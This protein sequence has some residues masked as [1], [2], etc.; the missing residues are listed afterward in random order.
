[1][2]KILFLILTLALLVN[3]SGA[4][5]GYIV[6]D[7]SN[8]DPVF[9]SLIDD[10]GFSYE[11]IDDSAIASTDFSD[12][13]ILLVGDE[14]IDNIPVDDYKTL[15]V[16]P[17]YYESWSSSTGSTSRND[18]YVTDVDIPVTEGIPGY[19]SPYVTCSGSICPRIHYLSGQK[20]SAHPVIITD[21]SSEYI[22]ATKEDP[23][24]VFFGA[25]ETD[26]WSSYTDN[27]FKNSIDWLMNIDIN[28][29]PV[30]DDYSPSDS[31]IEILIGNSQD[32]S[33][34]ASDEDSEITINWLVNGSNSGTG[35]SYNFPGEELGNF[36]ITAVVSDGE[37][38]L[39]QE[40][41]LHVLDY[42]DFTCSQLAGYKCGSDEICNGDIFQASD[43]E[44]CSIQ[45]SEKP[46]E[47]EKIKD[48]HNISSQ[49]ELEIREPTKSSFDLGEI[50]DSEIYLKNKAGKTLDFEIKVYFYDIIDDE[51]IE[52]YRE[53]AILQKD[54]GK[55]FYPEFEIPEDINEQSRYALFVKAIGDDDEDYYSED[56][57]LF[58]I[59]RKVYD[60]SIV[61]VEVLETSIK[62]DDYVE[63]IIKTENL[64]IRD[65]DVVVR[66]T[67][68][69][70]GIN[71]E[72]EE[73]KLEKYGED[74]KETSFLT[75][76]I[77][78]DAEKGK[79][80]LDI[81]AVF[82]N[83]NVI[84]K[85]EINLDACSE[86]TENIPSNISEEPEPELIKLESFQETETSEETEED[87]YSW[88]FN[89]IILVS[90]FLVAVLFVLLYL[91]VAAFFK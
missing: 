91:L 2:K 12:Y 18:A 69:E 83:R 23:R 44:C 62:C 57:V 68:S 33:V 58:N 64:G 52:E 28:D 36:N 29:P 20:Y 19:F 77:P 37:F 48:R 47:F 46:P 3:V 90:A 41:E 10:L 35:E 89:T 38:E 8:P 63:L 5:I 85:T 67:N 17:D 42:S 84:E 4:D 16:N 25:V 81:R 15:I 74:S 75:I 73:F 30:I 55:T 14:R 65:Q 13:E 40:W 34:D 39:F 70:L 31:I 66:V 61:D 22:I 86:E 71:I 1:M 79:Y 45:C 27:L 78:E 72:S 54:K 43:G 59:N 53:S 88:L 24:R 87:S 51:I 21:D 80:F 26:Y 6:K 56:Y 11:L 7:T 60:I 49:I 50:I 82:S 76:K 9:T 32:F